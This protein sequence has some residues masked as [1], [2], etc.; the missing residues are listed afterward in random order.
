MRKS[1][2]KALVLA[3]VGMLPISASSTQ[4]RNV[5]RIEHQHSTLPF[6]DRQHQFSLV[7]ADLILR[8]HDSE[9]DITYGDFYNSRLSTRC[10]DG[11]LV[12]TQH[13]NMMG[14]EAGDVTHVC[15]GGF[16]PIRIEGA[17]DAL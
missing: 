1:H 16:D 10:E 8:A 11:R 12:V 4:A 15:P 9:L 7:C 3:A 6:C 17:I 13:L 2:G 14:D 5:E